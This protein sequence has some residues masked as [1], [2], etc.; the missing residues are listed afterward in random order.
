MNRVAR[1]GPGIPSFY[2]FLKTVSFSID[3]LQ[4]N[5]F[6]SFIRVH[7][8]HLDVQTVCFTNV[9]EDKRIWLSCQDDEMKFRTDVQI[10]LRT[11]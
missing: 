7:M 1:C 9:V 2:C 8:E 10:I 4:M 3:F 11:T 5:S 6:N